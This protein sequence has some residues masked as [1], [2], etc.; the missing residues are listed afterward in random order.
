MNLEKLLKELNGKKNGTWFKIEWT[1]DLQNKLCAAAKREGHVVTKNVSTTVRKGIRYANMASV[2]ERLISEGK[3]LVDPLT[4]E[5]HVFPEKLS[6]GEWV[7]GS[8]VLI[9]HKD[10]YYVRL[11]TSPNTPKIQYFLDG[12]AI[13]AEELKSKGLLQPAYWTSGGIQECMTLKVSNI[14]KIY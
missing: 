9:R 11:Y 2:K 8:D 5:T 6:W 7:D 10:Q 12:I 14:N 4:G 13:A 1:T 3:F